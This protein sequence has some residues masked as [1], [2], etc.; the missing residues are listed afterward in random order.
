[1]ITSYNDNNHQSIY[2]REINMK[3]LTTLKRIG[4]LFLTLAMVLTMTV[5]VLPAYAAG[6]GSISVL[7]NPSVELTEKTNFKLYKVGTFN[8]DS[9][10]KS[11]IDLEKA[12]KDSKVN[13]NIAI[14]ENEEDRKED[15]EWHHKWL[16]AAS[17]LE[18][19]I[20]TP[21]EGKNIP[22]PD[23]SGAL[24][25]SD[26]YQKIG[27]FDNGIYLLIGDEQLV[28]DQFWSPVPVLIMVLN[29]ETQ[30]DIINTD[31][32]METRPVVH[33]HTVSKVWQDTEYEGG[34]PDSITVGIYYGETQ[35]DT[36]KLNNENNWTY[37]WYSQEAVNNDSKQKLERIY[38][39]KDPEDS[40]SAGVETSKLNENNKYKL[41]LPEGEALWRVD[42]LRTGNYKVDENAYNRA[43]DRT[44][45]EDATVE[46]FRIAN[47]VVKPARHDPPVLKTISGDT[48]EVDEMFEFSL[49]AIE[50]TAD[51]DEMPM[52]EGS[53]GNL[54]IMKAKAGVEKEFGWIT[55][56]HP[57]RY[58]YEIKELNTG[59]E[60][61]KYDD[62]VYVL[63]YDLTVEGEDLVMKLTTTKDGEVVDIATYEFVNEYTAPDEDTPAGKPKTGDDNNIVAPAVAF[64]IALILLII[65]LI[66][67]RKSNDSE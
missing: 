67:R 2:D 10:G 43:V 45:S 34:R 14:P 21:A 23:W 25:K 58:I 27:D 24:G 41:D 8:H 17:N 28:G 9:E 62:T 47:T 61:Y 40:K 38:T 54:K 64:G 48:P 49:T 35:L 44:I 42:E 16:D 6:S 51:V 18:N 39:S 30:F 56:R 63:T 26:N 31:L 1:M 59:A 53:E 12:Y 65:F 15:S 52:P 29:D 66:K 19:W 4:S 11:V 50:T 37:T 7:Y 60:N 32:K 33:K 36:V 55:F 20:S 13:L 5:T 57:G 3:N 46:Q 22:D